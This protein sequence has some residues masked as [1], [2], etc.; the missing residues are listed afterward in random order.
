[1]VALKTAFDFRTTSAVTFVKEKLFF[2]N[3]AYLATEAMSAVGKRSSAKL[4]GMTFI[5]DVVGVIYAGQAMFIIRASE[6]AFIE[7]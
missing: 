4:T 3:D 2:A 7:V 5:I 1:L 6:T